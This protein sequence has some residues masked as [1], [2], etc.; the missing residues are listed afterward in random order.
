MV[1]AALASPDAAVR[2]Q[3]VRLT[4]HPP[5]AMRREVVPLL[6]DP[7]AEVRSAALVAA[8]MPGDGEPIIADED[9]FRWLHDP[10]ESVRKVCRDALVSRDRTEAEIALGRRLTNPDPRERLMLLLDLRYGRRAGRPGAVA[11]AAQPRHRAGRASRRGAG[12]GGDPAE[13]R[14]GCPAWVDRVADTDPDPTVRR[15][16]AISGAVSSAPA[17]DAIRPAGG[18]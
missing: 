14:L 11:G 18:P 17:A 10:D 16:A 5:I 2:V 4:L 13:R 8:A 6:A 7:D 1:A 9:L 12:R 3:A 15:V